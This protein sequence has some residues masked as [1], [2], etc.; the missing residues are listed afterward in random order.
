MGFCF[1]GSG[2]GSGGSDKVGY[3]I[4]ESFFFFFY[5]IWIYGGSY[6]GCGCGWRIGGF[7]Y[8]F[9]LDVFI[10]L[11]IELEKREEFNW[12][13]FGDRDFYLFFGLF[14]DIIFYLLV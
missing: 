14:W 4:D 6:G 5:V 10:V 13:G 12:V 1:F 3:S 8:G 2:W 9:S 7:V 11:E